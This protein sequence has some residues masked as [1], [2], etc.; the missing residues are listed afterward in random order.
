ARRLAVRAYAPTLAAASGAS[1]C[2]AAGVSVPLPPYPAWTRRAARASSAPVGLPVRLGETVWVTTADGAE[3][4]GTITR[5]SPTDIAVSSKYGES[6]IDVGVIRR[7]D[8]PDSLVNGAKRG[9]LLGGV[10]AA[11]LGLLVSLLCE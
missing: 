7:V 9:S 5:V 8:A 6:A 1:P 11:R 10:S 4:H 2:N 3:V